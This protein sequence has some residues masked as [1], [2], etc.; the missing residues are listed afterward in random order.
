LDA[1]VQ[2]GFTFSHKPKSFVSRIGVGDKTR[3]DG[4]VAHLALLLAL[5]SVG[6]SDNEPNMLLQRH[7]EGAAIRMRLLDEGLCALE[8]VP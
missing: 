1:K 7:P 2:T 4:G 8:E 5:P 6:M 3:D